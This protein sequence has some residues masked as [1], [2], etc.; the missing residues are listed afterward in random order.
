MD[1]QCYQIINLNCNSW[2]NSEI[3]VIEDRRVKLIFSWK[4][5]KTAG[6]Q[7]NFKSIKRTLG[8]LEHSQHHEINIHNKLSDNFHERMSTSMTCPNWSGASTTTV[9]WTRHEAETCQTC[10]SIG[11]ENWRNRNRSNRH[12]LFSMQRW[13][14]NVID[15]VH[16]KRFHHTWYDNEN[17][18][19]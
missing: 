9:A 1:F 3:K 19:Y 5:Q 17:L 7:G 8:F 12:T 6:F 15:T 10:M 13:G 14:K 18:A 16:N 4:T 2:K 11:A